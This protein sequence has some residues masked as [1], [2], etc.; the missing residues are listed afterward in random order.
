MIAHSVSGRFYKN[1]HLPNLLC[2]AAYLEAKSEGYSVDMAYCND[3]RYNLD[4][5]SWT[6]ANLYEAFPF[7]N[8]IY[9]V[10]MKG[11]KNLSE[12]RDYNYVYHDASLTETNVNTWYT[13]AVIDYLLFH[14]SD[15]REYNYFSFNSNYMQILGTLKKNNGDQYLYRDIC[16]DYL[17]SLTGTLRSSDYLT[18]NAEFT[19]PAVV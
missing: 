7:D 11:S 18:S 10:K 3:A 1:Q 15:N 8:V 16:A 13:V 9:V 6:Y 4:T 14:T 2:K 19:K 5:G 17:R 12:I